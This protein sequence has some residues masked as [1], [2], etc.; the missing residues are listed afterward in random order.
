MSGLW[1]GRKNTEKPVRDSH[2]LRYFVLLNNFTFPLGVN[3]VLPVYLYAYLSVLLVGCT[4]GAV[5]V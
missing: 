4:E 1:R 5:R 2:T 3:K